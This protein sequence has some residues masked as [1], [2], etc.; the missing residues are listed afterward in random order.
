M[1]VD[2]QVDVIVEKV[3]VKEVD[4]VVTVKVCLSVRPPVIV[5]KVVVKEVMR[6]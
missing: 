6:S 4:V 5:E 2:G 3:V 1:N